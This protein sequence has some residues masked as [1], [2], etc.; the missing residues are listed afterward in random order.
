M[1]TIDLMVNN[2][3]WEE[4]LTERGIKIKVD[5]MFP[6]LV[7]LCYKMTECTKTDPIVMECRG[8]VVD[9]G[10][11]KVSSRPFDRFFNYGESRDITEKVNYENC[12]IQ[13]KLDGSLVT[14]YYSERYSMWLVSTKGTPTARNAMV[15]DVL[16]G[17]ER[18][19]PL[20]Y[21]IAD[22]FGIA[23]DY[24]VSSRHMGYRQEYIDGSDFDTIMRLMNE[25]LDRELNRG[26][27]YICELVSP[28]NKVVKVYNKTEVYLLAVRDNLSGDYVDHE[29]TLFL[30]PTVYQ[31]NGLD[32]VKEVVSLLNKKGNGLH[33]G[34]VITCNDSGTRVK[35]KTSGYVMIHHN[36]KNESL[37]KDDMREVVA[38]GEEDEVVAYF[39]HHKNDFDILVEKRTKALSML[40]YGI[41]LSVTIDDRKELALKL[42]DIGIASPIFYAMKFSYTDSKTLWENIPV[43]MKIELLK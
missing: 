36:L 12:K 29:P 40:S 6:K 39:P 19:L 30:K 3:N 24:H 17:E 11:F 27:T 26:Y 28:K 4:L 5:P 32:E 33:E 25:I 2:C 7:N 22:Y 1:H 8:L 18:G 31:C 21:L 10:N 34:V 14:F 16:N 9:T 42:K 13:D 23:V 35:M 37:S 20:L 41:N 43:K 15:V 38:Y